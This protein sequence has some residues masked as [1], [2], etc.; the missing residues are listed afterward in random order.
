MSSGGT[1]ALTGLLI[2]GA[3]VWIGGFV[4]IAVV[5]RVA[6]RTLTPDARVSLFRALGR[7][8]G[9]VAT[10]ALVLAYGSGAALVR[11][12]PW[13]GVL[14]ATCVAAAALVVTTAV[15][16]GQARH[17]SRL[18]RR[19]LDDTEDPEIGRQVS[20]GALRA[21]LLRALIGLLSLAVLAGGVLV[22]T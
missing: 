6:G 9:I 17:M 13:D 15:G 3:S 12:R 18:R 10:A 21:G 22:G 14:A 7:S 16:V 20:R 8:Y 11:G 19:A 5:A 4:A 2:F 1:A